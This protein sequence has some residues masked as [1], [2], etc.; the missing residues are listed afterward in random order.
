MATDKVSTG[1]RRWNEIRL[2]FKLNGNVTGIPYERGPFTLFL[3][4]F[5]SKLE[6]R[7]I[8][9]SFGNYLAGKT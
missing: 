1:L 2:I 4:C 9:A 6:F 8:I 5:V 3:C 7:Q